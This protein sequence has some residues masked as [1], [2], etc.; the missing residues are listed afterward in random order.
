M[1]VKEVASQNE[2]TPPVLPKLFRLDGQTGHLQAEQAEQ[3]EEF[4]KESEF[5]YLADDLSHELKAMKNSVSTMGAMHEKQIEAIDIDNIFIPEY[6]QGGLP[7][8]ARINR[9]VMRYLFGTHALDQH[10]HPH[11]ELCQQPTPPTS[12]Y[13]PPWPPPSR[14]SRRLGRHR[15]TGRLLS[16]V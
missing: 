9:S 10:H 4:E 15:Q 12:S 13:P 16:E 8:P 14:H 3:A 5:E 2:P 6:Q 7:V 1:P 11:H